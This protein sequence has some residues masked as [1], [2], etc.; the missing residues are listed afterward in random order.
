MQESERIT[1][2]DTL[3]NVMN[4]VRQKL[5]KMVYHIRCRNAEAL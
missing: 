5:Y 4:L 1:N 3:N 2:E